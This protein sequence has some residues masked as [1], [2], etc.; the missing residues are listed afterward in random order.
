MFSQAGRST[1]SLSK[2]VE[3]AEMAAIPSSLPMIPQ[4][5]SRTSIER[6]PRNTLLSAAHATPTRKL[7]SQSQPSSS[8]LEVPPDCNYLPSSPLQP[9]PSA[10]LFAAVPDSAVKTAPTSANNHGIQDTPIKQRPEIT[11]HGHPL[12]SSSNKET[13][14]ATK[15]MAIS[16]T[17]DIKSSQEVSIYKSLGW[18][19]DADELS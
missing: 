12:Y 19:D 18:D 3:E 1:L 6:L 10:Q 14:Q 5:V 17:R 15:K 4:S 11:D 7:T 8:F 9:R 16:G 2:M 13:G